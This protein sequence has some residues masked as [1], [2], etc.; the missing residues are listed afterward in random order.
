[1]ALGRRGWIE[2]EG[3]SGVTGSQVAAAGEGYGPEEESE[4]ALAL[5]RY[6]RCSLYISYKICIFYIF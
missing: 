2:T 5:S 3:E 1:M 4:I 6:S